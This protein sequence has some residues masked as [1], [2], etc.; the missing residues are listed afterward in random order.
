MQRSVSCSITS[1]LCQFNSK[2]KI[3]LH[4]LTQLHFPVLGREKNLPKNEHPQFKL[5][6]LHKVKYFLFIFYPF[7]KETLQIVPS[8]VNL[9]KGNGQI[10]KDCGGPSNSNSNNSNGTVAL[11]SAILVVNMGLLL[12][13]WYLHHCRR[14]I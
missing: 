9:F 10:R 11:L 12:K 13:F 2:R 5:N 1:M 6:A 14:E 4:K 3:K 8:V 7:G